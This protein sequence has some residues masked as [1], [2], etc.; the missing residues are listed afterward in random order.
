MLMLILSTDQP[1]RTGKGPDA[2]RLLTGRGI[3]PSRHAG[4]LFIPQPRGE[5]QDL[6]AP[7]MRVVPCLDDLAASLER[8]VKSDV[9]QRVPSAR[10]SQSRLGKSEHKRRDWSTD[11]K[12]ADGFHQGMGMH[13]D[14]P[15]TDDLASRIRGFA[16]GERTTQCLKVSTAMILPSGT[17]RDHAAPWVHGDYDAIR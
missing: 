1:A 2:L 8:T 11:L 12:H 9:G 14:Q 6:D 4:F 13:V 17:F 5:S 10:C 3:I 16:C 7:A 15:G